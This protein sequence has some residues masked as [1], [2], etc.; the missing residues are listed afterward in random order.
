[1]K[2]RTLREAIQDNQRHYKY[3]RMLRR[4]RLRIFEYEDAGKLGKAHRVIDKIKAI[5]GQ[6]WEK[7]AKRQEEKRLSSLRWQ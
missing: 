7:R 1:M 3:E 2:Q 5:C 6:R 4:L